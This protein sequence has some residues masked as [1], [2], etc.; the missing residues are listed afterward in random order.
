MLLTICRSYHVLPELR[1][2][3]VDEIVFFY[4]GLRPDLQKSQPKPKK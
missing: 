4:D 3:T 1:S 2:M